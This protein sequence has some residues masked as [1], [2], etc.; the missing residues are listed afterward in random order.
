[1]SVVVPIVTV[2]S[3]GSGLGEVEVDHRR[4]DRRGA[5][6]AFGRSA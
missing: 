2:G 1:V 4:L 3:A 6:V 5:A